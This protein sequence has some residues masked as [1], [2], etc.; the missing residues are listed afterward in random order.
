MGLPAGPSKFITLADESADPE[1]LAR[2][3][4]IEGEHR[5]NSSSLLVTDS[6]QLAEAVMNVLPEKMAALPEWRQDLSVRYLR[7]QKEQVV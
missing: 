4:L 3:L 6:R 2:D 1:L 7:R 5:P